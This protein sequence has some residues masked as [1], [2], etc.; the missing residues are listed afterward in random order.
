VKLFKEYYKE[1]KE[2]PAFPTRYGGVK[3]DKHVFETIHPGVGTLDNPSLPVHFLVKHI[4][5]AGISPVSSVWTDIGYDSVGTQRSPET[6]SVK[7]C[8]KIGEKPVDGNSGRRE[9]SRD[10]INPVLYFKKVGVVAVLRL[11]HGR[12]QS[13]PVDKIERVCRGT[14]ISALIFNLFTVS[15]G[16]R[17]GTVYMGKGQIDFFP[18][19]FYIPAEGC[20][21]VSFPAPFPVMFEN[22]DERGWLSGK[23]MSHRE[24]TPLTAALQ[25]IKNGIDYFHKVEL[26][27][28]SAFCHTEMRHYSIFYCIFV[29]Y[30]VFWHWFNILQFGDHNIVHPLRNALYFISFISDLT[31]IN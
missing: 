21:P 8:V 14:L 25:F 1:S 30:S 29:E 31:F 5:L 4:F 28:V 22:G 13:L 27:G 10:L 11:G 17:M 3:A 24:Q 20:F 7:A 16:R 6:L 12:R 23:Q 19:L 26:T 9:L 2:V 15:V 18:A